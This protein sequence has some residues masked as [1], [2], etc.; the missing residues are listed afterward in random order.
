M[1]HDRLSSVNAWD[2]LVCL[3]PLFRFLFV[4]LV[5]DEECVERSTCA[6]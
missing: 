1:E 5:N 6:T 4:L 3:L 2:S